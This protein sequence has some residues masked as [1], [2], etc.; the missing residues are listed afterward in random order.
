MAKKEKEYEINSLER[1]LNVANV[2]NFER[3]TI[4]FLSWLH[5]YVSVID[6]MRTKHPELCK[7]KVNTEIMGSKF[8]WTDDGIVGLTSASIINTKTGEKTT[9]NFKKRKKI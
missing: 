4:D 1:L 7:D 8:I 9:T 6:S 2:E 5:H 3:L